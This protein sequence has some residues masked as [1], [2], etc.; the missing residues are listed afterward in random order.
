MWGHAALVE[1]V[2]RPVQLRAFE[3]LWRSLARLRRSQWGGACGG[4]I[5]AARDL[6][7]RC[8]LWVED[9][10]GNFVSKADAGNCSFISSFADM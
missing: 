1:A 8:A 7:R 5:H 4:C 2:A 10:P 3:W 6:A 9:C